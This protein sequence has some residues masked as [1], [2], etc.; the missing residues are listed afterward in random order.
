MVW[1]R[2]LWRARTA[3]WDPY[4]PPACISP[5]HACQYRGKSRQIHWSACFSFPARCVVLHSVLIAVF[6]ISLLI[7]VLIT[8]SIRMYWLYCVMSQLL[9]FIKLM[10][11]ILYYCWP[12]FGPLV[13]S[14]LVIG[15]S[16]HVSSVSEALVR[17]FQDN[18]SKPRLQHCHRHCSYALRR[19]T[20]DE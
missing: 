6:I 8:N 2:P 10:K 16:V 9:H 1:I 7:F 4:S 14:Q 3:I 5:S 11:Q 20:D 19:R 15:R 13:E 18:F 17:V 12:F